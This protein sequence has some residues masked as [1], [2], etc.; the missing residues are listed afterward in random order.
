MQC[1]HL[2]YLLIL[3]EDITL[4]ISDLIFS[5]ELT[6]SKAGILYI[7]GPQP[8]GH[9]P[10]LGLEQFGTGLRKWQASTSVHARGR[11]YLRE[12][13]A[14]ACV[15]SICMS[16]VCVCVCVCPLLAQNHSLTTITCQLA[17]PERLENSVLHAQNER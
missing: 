17:K 2:Y 10:L 4:Y 5:L 6:Y 3:V 14:S 11:P 16:G 13:W 9:R 15:H 12:E 1:P 8:L 7:R